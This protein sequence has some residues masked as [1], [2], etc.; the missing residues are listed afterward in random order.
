[1]ANN[2][3][4]TRLTV[5]YNLE[6]LVMDRKTKLGALT[7]GA[8]ETAKNL[9]DKAVQAVDQNDDGKLDFTDLS[10]IAGSMGNT[11]KKG[12]K[13]VKKN[14]GEK[15]RLFELK[16]LRPIF[17]DSL[18]DADFLM[19]KFI[20]IVDRDKKRAESEVCQGSI[21]FE[22]D[23]KGLYIVNIFRDSIDAFNLMF[24]P[25]CDGEFY[26]I[27]PSERQ[28]YIVLDEYFSYLKISRVNEL[29]KIAQALGA[30]HFKVTYKEEQTS[31]SEKKVK[32]HIKAAAMITADSECESS[33]KKYATIEV[34]AEMEFPGHTPIKPQLKY[35]QKD[36]SIQTLI[37]MR[38]NASAP[39]L[40]EKFMLKMSNSSGMKESDAMKIDAVLKELKCSGNTTL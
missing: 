11:V 21:G 19:P 36:S 28:R 38:M 23:Q 25:D 35:L 30:K 14:V 6:E 29:R 16:S 26:Y 17:P 7:S 12:A 13:A 20:R 33:Q 8:G 4:L 9:L 18:D 31:F 34:A 1:M 27:D 39:L 40:H 10:V 24:Y 32:S 15:T 5:D 3:K 2:E 22:S 37:A